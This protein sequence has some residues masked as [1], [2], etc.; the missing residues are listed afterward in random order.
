MKHCPRVVDLYA[1]AAGLDPHR[2]ATVREHAEQCETC[3][4][5][6][7][8]I[9]LA[10]AAE[11]SEAPPPGEG[12]I[13]RLLEKPAEPHDGR[14]RAV[15]SAVEGRAFAGNLHA[16]ENMADRPDEAAQTMAARVRERLE[17]AWS[18]TAGYALRLTDAA[19]SLVRT[20]G[21]AAG[22][23]YISVV[24]TPLPAPA[25]AGVRAP[26]YD[27]V[28]MTEKEASTVLPIYYSPETLLNMRVEFSPRGMEL[29]AD[30]HEQGRSVEVVAL[31]INGKRHEGGHCIA[32]PAANWDVVVESEHG[33]TYR[34][35]VGLE[36]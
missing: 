18:Y 33:D 2:K 13:L 15:F 3:F 29:W 26:L 16:F 25:L 5:T 19:G 12:A 34:A 23:L 28:A 7:T 31:T 11:P 6:L 8:E 30:L 1:A 21:E 4:D 17:S 32:A 10:L 35:Q 24:S 9:A 22:Q 36:Q 20:L 27:D 14:V